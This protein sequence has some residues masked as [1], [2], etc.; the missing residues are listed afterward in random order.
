[1]HPDMHPGMHPGMYGGMY[2]GMP[3]PVDP[4]TGVP[5]PFNPAA[6]TPVHP[7]SVGMGFGANGVIPM[8]QGEALNI[9][10]IFSVHMQI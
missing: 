7:S 2:G 9:I 8:V 4:A 6:F 3:P 10:H 5:L 1:M